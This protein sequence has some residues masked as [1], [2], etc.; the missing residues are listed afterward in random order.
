[1]RQD[2]RAGTGGQYQQLTVHP[3]HQVDHRCHD[4]RAGDGGDRGGAGR[5]AD[6]RRHQPCQHDR[7]NFCLHSHLPDHVAYAGIH[8]HLLEATASADDQ[9]DGGSR[10]QALVEHLHD[11]L[12]VE[13]AGRA[14]GVEGQ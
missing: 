3:R 6:H 8:Q 5:D 13:A 14:E 12:A 1:M 10:C 7:R 11:L 9:H 2:Q 4:T